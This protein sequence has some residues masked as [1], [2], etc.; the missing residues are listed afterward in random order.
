MLIVISRDGALTVDGRLMP[1]TDL[2]GYLHLGVARN[3]EKSVIIQTSTDAPYHAMTKVF[4][5]LRQAG[6]GNVVIPTNAEL[7]LYG[8]QEPQ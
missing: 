1:L 5:E 4:D 3:P 2:I 6:V 8:L 7:A